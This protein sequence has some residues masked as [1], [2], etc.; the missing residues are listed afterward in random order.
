MNQGTLKQLSG[1]KYK[2]HQTI[3]EKV[4]IGDIL[5]HCL[6]VVHK[7]KIK[8]GNNEKKLAKS[9]MQ[10]LLCTFSLLLTA[11]WDQVAEEFPLDKETLDSF[12]ILLHHFF[13]VHSTDDDQHDLLTQSRNARLPKQMKTQ[14]AT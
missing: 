2:I 13:E 10:V 7:I 9:Y 11:T 3:L 8:V 1:E 4:E 12:N 14:P 5:T 6:Q